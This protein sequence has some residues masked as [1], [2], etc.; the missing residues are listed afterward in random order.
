[1]HIFVLVAVFD[2]VSQWGLATPL[3]MVITA[4]LTFC[5]SALLTRIIALLPKSK[6]LIG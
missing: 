5:I 3:V 4:A 1:M 6:F 2:I